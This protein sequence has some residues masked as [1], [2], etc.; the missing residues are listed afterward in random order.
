MN[1]PRL[2]EPVSR[3]L[4]NP[5]ST[6][7]D[8]SG[9]DAADDR[10]IRDI[11]HHHGIRA[12]DHVIADPDAA[13]H[14]GAR[15]KIHPIADRGRAKGIGAAAVANCDTVTDQAVIAD[16]RIAMD[17]DTAMVHYTQ[18]A[19]DG[20]R[21]ANHNSAEDLC[22]L[23]EDYVDDRPGCPQHLVADGETGVA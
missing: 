9:R 22:E 12:D 11:L 21:G 19:A 8:D 7:P 20:A 15:P 3:R 2:P 13:Q 14:L 5:A 1:A 6:N 17:D 23:V 10:E 16:D 18:T 4:R